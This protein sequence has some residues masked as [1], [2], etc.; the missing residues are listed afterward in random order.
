MSDLDLLASSFAKLFLRS[1][2]LLDR[3]M[4]Q[5]GA[6][7]ARTKLLMFVERDGP[8]RAIDIATLFDLAPRSVTEALDGLER[9][10]LIRRN[11]DPRDRRVKLV[12][13][14]DAGRRAIAA[15]EPIRVALIG[16]VFGVLDADE[17]ARMLD[18][19]AR[20]GAALDAEDGGFPPCGATPRP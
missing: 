4:A 18:Y 17:Q 14:T 20:M 12:S 6:S 8:V 11:P 16:R 7:F 9:D 15:T 2:R 5:A 19:I 3:R 1:H 13:I 10:G